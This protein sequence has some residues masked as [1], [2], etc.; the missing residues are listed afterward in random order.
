MSKHKSKDYKITIV[1]YYL[2]KPKKEEI[3]KIVQK[4]IKA[5]KSVKIDTLTKS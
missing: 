3:K 5:N 2:E 1:K 4:K